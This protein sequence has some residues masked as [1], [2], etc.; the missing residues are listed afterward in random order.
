M[1]GRDGTGG[2]GGWEL[3]EA[4]H[5]QRNWTKALENTPEWEANWR[6]LVCV[7]RPG[8]A[9]D[10]DSGGGGLRS[11]SRRGSESQGTP[12]G[13]SYHPAAGPHSA[14]TAAPGESGH[15]GR[16]THLLGSDTSPC[17]Q[18][19]PP[20]PG[21]PRESGRRRRARGMR[22]SAASRPAMPGRERAAAAIAGRAHGD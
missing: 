2:Q 13:S 18:E 1:T 9:W 12:Q 3:G 20:R 6:T 17:A 22:D 16:T 11:C 4:T 8:L 21:P 5:G 14:E 19:W 10:A 15:L 7:P